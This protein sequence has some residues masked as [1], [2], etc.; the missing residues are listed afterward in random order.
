MERTEV[1][2]RCKGT[3]SV[4]GKPCTECNGEGTINYF[5]YHCAFDESESRNPRIYPQHDTHIES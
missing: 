2:P 5:K 3:K 1:C 4:D